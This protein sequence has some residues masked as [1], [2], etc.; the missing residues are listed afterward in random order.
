MNILRHSAFVRI[1]T[2]V[3]AGGFQSI[4]QAREPLNRVKFTHM[5]TYTDRFSQDGIISCHSQSFQEKSHE[6]IV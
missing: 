4:L 3:L 1:S 2:T 5:S 6:T